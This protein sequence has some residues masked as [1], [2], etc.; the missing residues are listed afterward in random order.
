MLP[1]LLLTSLGMGAVFMPLTLIATTGLEDE[2]QGLASG[3]FNT[4][5]QIGGALGLAILS[6]IAAEQDATRAAADN[7]GARA[8]LPLGV[9]RRR[10]VRRSPALVVDARA[11]APAPRR[12]DRGGGAAEPRRA[13]RRVTQLRADA[14]RNLGRVLDAAAEVLRRARAPTSRVDEIA[15]RAGVGHGTVF[16]RFPT[17]DALIAAVVV[18]RLRELIAAAEEA[19]ARRRMRPRRSEAFML[20]VAQQHVRD[21]R[22]F[23]CF[24]KCVGDARADASCTRSARSSSNARRPPARCGRS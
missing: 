19:L 18:E 24:D 14:Q 5:Q 13:D 3:L 4:S 6:T 2:D 11:A 7:A 23:E 1:S 22:L 9:R 21:R 10:A 15:R 16:R 8:R 12:P 20:R 17:K